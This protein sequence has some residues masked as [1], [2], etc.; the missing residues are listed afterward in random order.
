MQEGEDADRREV[1]G[2]LPL[3]LTCTRTRERPRPQIDR[4]TA[5]T[6]LAERR[7]R[8]LSL[9]GSLVCVPVCERIVIFLL[10]RGP[11]VGGGQVPLKERVEL[12]AVALPAATDAGRRSP[13]NSIPSLSLP[14]E[15][16]ASS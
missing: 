15:V 7:A 8:A 12:L 13:Q 3:P 14:G 2:G 4:V 16:F 1:R 11:P 9:A 6:R 5:E 10:P